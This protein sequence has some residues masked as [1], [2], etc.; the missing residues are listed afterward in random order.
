MDYHASSGLVVAV[1]LGRLRELGLLHL[2][3]KLW[4]GSGASLPLRTVGVS[5]TARAMRRPP[6]EAVAHRRQLII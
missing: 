6:I 3:L 4:P 1:G 5:S 2:C